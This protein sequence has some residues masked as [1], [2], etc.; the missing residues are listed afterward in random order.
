MTDDNITS[1]LNL[2]LE[3]ADKLSQSTRE[4]NQT[5]RALNAEYI[6]PGPGNDPVR[7][8][9]ALPTGRNFYGFDQRKFPDE[10]TQAMGAVL[11][12]QLVEN[13]YNSH[14]STYP[15]KVSYVL[16][17]MET[18]RHGKL[19]RLPCYWLGDLK[20]LLRDLSYRFWRKPA[21]KQHRKL[22]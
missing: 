16:W 13:Y 14:N 19:F 17:A 3:Y 6:E 1:D 2:G 8:P 22:K 10:E 7:N 11:A 15:E 5:L 12:D 18:L 4:I 20:Q 21:R 9:D